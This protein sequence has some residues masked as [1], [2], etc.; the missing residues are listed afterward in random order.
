MPLFW[1]QGQVSITNYSKVH[2]RLRWAQ[3][4]LKRAWACRG[5]LGGSVIASL[6]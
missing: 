1:G 6:L 5:N 2:M 4:A 3:K